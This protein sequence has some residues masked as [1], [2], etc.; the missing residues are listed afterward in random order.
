[1]NWTRT[2]EN[3]TFRTR[4]VRLRLTW[5]PLCR[6]NKY[7]F[8]THQIKD[9]RLGD[10]RRITKLSLVQSL[11]IQSSQ[12]WTEISRQLV[13]SFAQKNHLL[14]FG[15]NHNMVSDLYTNF[16]VAINIK[17]WCFGIKYNP[18]NVKIE[19]IELSHKSYTLLIVV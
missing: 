16:M 1:M 15:F 11:A 3:S 9:S 2:I 7:G 10:R 8:W 19:N 17:L 12:L 18:I 14:F 4:L 6:S 5:F 13:I